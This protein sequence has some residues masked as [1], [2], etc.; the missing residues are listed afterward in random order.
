MNVLW[1]RSIFVIPYF[2]NWMLPVMLDSL[3]MAFSSFEGFV[4]DLSVFF[5]DSGPDSSWTFYPPLHVIG[6]PELSLGVVIL[7]LNTVGIG[8]LLGAVNFM[9]LFGIC[10]LLLLL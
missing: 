10:A 4:N 2:G 1:E 3:E 8:S 5:I 6:E 9:L 7:G